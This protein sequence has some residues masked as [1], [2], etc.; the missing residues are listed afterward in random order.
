MGKVLIGCEQSGI[1]RNAFVVLGH[2]AYSCDL[3][4]I[5]TGIFILLAVGKIKLRAIF[6]T[7]IINPTIN[8]TV[9][10]WEDLCPRKLRWQACGLA[11]S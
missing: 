9:V 10:E 5:H 8:E 7:L 6:F 3:S 11:Q 2:D 1:V 4:A